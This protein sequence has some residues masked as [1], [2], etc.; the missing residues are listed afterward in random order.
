MITCVGRWGNS[1]AEFFSL[2]SLEGKPVRGKRE[3][4]RNLYEGMFAH[5]APGDFGQL[6]VCI[7]AVGNLDVQQSMVWID[8]ASVSL[9]GWPRVY[10]ARQKGAQKSSQRLSSQAW[11]WE[12]DCS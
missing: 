8:G 12:P 4:D 11:A 7:D 5:R 6:F 1:L 9:T 3:N 10:M 2:S